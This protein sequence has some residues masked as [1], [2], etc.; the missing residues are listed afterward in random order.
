MNATT[1]ENKN[2]KAVSL[3]SVLL[4]A[5]DSYDAGLSSLSALYADR[6]KALEVLRSAG[7]KS[8]QS[9][10]ALRYNKDAQPLTGEYPYTV[11]VSEFEARFKA[12]K[13]N[14][15]QKQIDAN[16]KQ[17]VAALNFWLINGK[18]TSN[19]GKDRVRLEHEVANEKFSEATLEAV[20]ASTAAKIAAR[21]A[22]ENKKLVDTSSKSITRL[23]STI[24]DLT[25]KAKTSDIHAAA[26]KIA[27][28]RAKLER[29]NLAKLK[30]NL[31]IAEVES[32]KAAT[33]KNK[34]NKAAEA[35]KQAAADKAAAELEKKNK[36]ADMVKVAASLTDKYT[37][38]QIKKLIVELQ[39]TI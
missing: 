8:V 14:A 11:A 34:A 20:R 25:V 16:N 32:K 29:S 30:D 23:E 22:S 38:E 9:G 19:V 6:A 7:F 2:I 39:K 18:F 3:L 31:K 26:L 5:T 35:T 1:Q 28:G 10:K 21:Q 27:E 12:L 24:K 36:A 15:T 4:N 17:R 13:P 37:A 33:A